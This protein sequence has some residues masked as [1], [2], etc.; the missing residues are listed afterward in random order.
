ML[1]PPSALTLQ[2]QG[3]PHRNCPTKLFLDKKMVAIF[4]QWDKNLAVKFCCTLL[5][6]DLGWYLSSQIV[7]FHK[8][9]CNTTKKVVSLLIER[10]IIRIQNGTYY[11]LTVVVLVKVTGWSLPSILVVY[12]GGSFLNNMRACIH[13]R[14]CR[15]ASYKIMAGQ[16]QQGSR[17][18]GVHVKSHLHGFIRPCRSSVP[19]V[20]DQRHALNLMLV[21]QVNLTG[22]L[23][24]IKFVVSLN[25]WWVLTW[26]GFQHTQTLCL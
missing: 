5:T 26:I 15:A 18:T 13:T 12:A 4:C 2:L 11:I 7:E 6:F 17:N 25:W 9:R 14:C 23:G 16:T 10:K 8:L 19:T 1:L 24:A 21:V 22:I 3:L 20:D